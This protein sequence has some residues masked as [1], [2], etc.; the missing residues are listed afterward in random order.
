M[1]KMESGR[2]SFTVKG[3]GPTDAVVVHKTDQ[4]RFREVRRRRGASIFH[5][6]D[7]RHESLALSERGQLVRTPLVVSVHLEVVALIDD[8]T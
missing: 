6:A 3:M 1:T 8:E 4:V 7:G 5:L 2:A